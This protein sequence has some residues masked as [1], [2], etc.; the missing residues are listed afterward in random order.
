M[1]DKGKGPINRP[2]YDK[3]KKLGFENHRIKDIGNYEEVINL[4]KPYT[5]TGKSSVVALVDAVKFVCNNKIPGSIIECGVWKGGS[6]MAVAKTLLDLKQFDRELYLFDTFEGMTK[7]TDYDQGMLVT[8]KAIFQ[9]EEEKISEDS[10]NWCNTP[11]DEVKKAVYSVGYDK[12]KIHFIK[13]KV[14]DTIPEKSPKKI[15]LL[16]LDTDWYESTHHELVHLFPRISNGGVIIIDDYDTWKGAKKAV[17]EYISNNKV[18]LMLNRI[19]RGGR[20]GVK[21]SN[22][23]KN[24][25]DKILQ[26]ILSAK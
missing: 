26:K 13:G 22:R 15:S 4:V 7:P 9:F 6:M 11:L 1:K 2:L 3:I 21:N 5:M 20:I 16:R 25:I 24:L 17:D 10:S 12:E 8:K 19:F 14:E 23:N 18:P